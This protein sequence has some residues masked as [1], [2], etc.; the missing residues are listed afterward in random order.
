MGRSPGFASAP[1]SSAPCS[2]SLSLRVP[3]ITAVAL[4]SRGQ[5][6]GS[7]CK[8][9]AVTPHHREAGGLRPL[10]GARFQGL[11]TPLVGV[12]FTFPSRY[13]FAIGLS[14]VFSLS[15]WCRSIRTGFLRPRPTQVPDTAARLTRTGVS[16]SAPRFPNRFRFVAPWITRV[17]QPR[18]TYA[19]RFGLLR[20]RSPLLAESLSYS[21]LLRVLRCFSS[22]GSPHRARARCLAPS[23]ARGLPH[24]EI[25]G[26]KVARTSPR[27]FAASHV[28][29]R[30]RQPRHPPCALLTLP[31]SRRAG[32]N[33]GP[34]Q[35]ALIGF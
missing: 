31:H 23:P 5:L 16:P 27:L 21:P 8:R 17:L 7:L 24:S 14:G 13:S 9:H 33:L 4:A 29:P 11:F 32:A 25:R 30:L 6:V 10:V 1:T 26:S 3:A 12:L 19:P 22:P 2:D 34:H 20:F 35:F 18:G 15:G 28:L